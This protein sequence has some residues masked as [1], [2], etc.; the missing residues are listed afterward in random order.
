MLKWLNS[1]FGTK[2][3]HSVD[4]V[5][6]SFDLE[7]LVP[8]DKNAPPRSSWYVGNLITP[9]R[10]R[11]FLSILFFGLTVLGGR[12]FQLQVVRGAELSLQA[13]RN[14]VRVIPIVAERGVVYDRFG[15]ELTHNVPSFSLSIVPQGLPNVR[16]QAA[17]RAALIERIAAVAEVPIEEVHKRLERARAASYQS[18]TIKENLSY[19]TALSLY[20]QNDD[21][22][23]M[24]IETGVKRWYGLVT[25]KITRPNVLS[26]LSTTTTPVTPSTT[27]P[28]PS[29]MSHLLGYLGK[30]TDE[31]WET[32][33]DQG[34]LQTDALGKSGL[35]RS[36]ESVLRGAYGKKTIEID[37]L[38]REQR[39]VSVEA[40][41]PGN[42]LFLTID[43]EAQRVLE[44]AVQRTLEK[45]KKTR[46]AAI[47]LNPNT[48]AIY[49]L[50]SYPS[51]NNND[52]S[53]GISAVRYKEYLD[54]PD[55]PLFNRAIGGAYPPGSTLK[56]VVAA[57]AFEEG[58][59]NSRTSFL[60]TGGLKTGDR[61]F[62]DWKAGGHGITNVTK[63]LAWSVNTFFYYVGGG[64]EDFKGVGIRT[65]ATYLTRFGLGAKTGLDIPGE[66]TGY[67]PT[68]DAKKER[69]GQD[70]YVG[71]TYNVSIGQGDTIVSPL[72]VAVWTA[73][74]ANGGKKIQ[75]HLV[76]TIVNPVTKEKKTQSPSTTPIGL[77][78][79]AV[80]I[81]RQGMRECVTYGS[82]NLLRNLPFT[83]GGKT[84]TAQW[85]RN[86]DTH[87]W[88]TSFAPYNSPQI[89]VTVIV[90]EGGEGSVAAQPVARDFLDWWGK[91]Y[92]YQNR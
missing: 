46:A 3:E 38:D 82:C 42:N 88:F 70:W 59:I 77:S 19:E 73:A 83:S 76:E 92:L 86:K 84:G 62:P 45:N 7:T 31:E 11:W 24:V 40:P 44:E 28:L 66:Q 69:T 14:R 34:Y 89:V 79:D 21:F 54:N 80:S 74:F 63:A 61:F 37:A 50:V 15:L 65:L 67:V 33:K 55:H 2:R 36:Y 49:A 75:P 58:I 26:V 4:W 6:T 48:G 8:I 16:T 32:L 43:L 17:E 5:E 90:E 13:E 53:G 20:L 72:H 9:R 51:F 52:F 87:A 10:R 91:K 23:G 22:P 41:V 30:V 12:V 78:T 27:S 25:P 57:A 71:D 56:P 18:L 68:P 85:N 35:E 60:S 39:V 64:Y 47:A 81:V 29:S 1:W